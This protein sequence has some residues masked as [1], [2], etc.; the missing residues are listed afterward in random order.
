VAAKK[1][2]ALAGAEFGCFVHQLLVARLDYSALE[3]D[4]HSNV[5]F[6]C[7]SDPYQLDPT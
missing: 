2:A 4:D 6:V 1:S 7:A 3:S 5:S